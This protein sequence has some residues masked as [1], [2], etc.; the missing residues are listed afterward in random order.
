MGWPGRRTG[1]IATLPALEIGLGLVVLVK[2]TLAGFH[3]LVDGLDKVL[4]LFVLAKELLA[5][6]E[7]SNAETVALDIFVMPVAGADFLAILNGVAAQGHSRT[8]PVTMID[9]VLGQ[10]LLYHLHNFRFREKF[11]R[12]PLHVLFRKGLGALE[13][14]VKG[15]LPLQLVPPRGKTVSR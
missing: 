4:T 5:H 13:R 7:H 12:P 15:Q 2:Q 8:V 10:P 6:E 14:L 9:L 3:R 11:V 1:L